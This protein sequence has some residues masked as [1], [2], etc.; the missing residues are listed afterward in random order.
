MPGTGSRQSARTTTRCLPGG[1]HR[2]QLERHVDALVLADQLPVDPH[3]RAMVH[4]LEA[5]RV[6][7]VRRDA[8]RRPVPA[9]AAVEVA[10]PDRARHRPRVGHVGTC[11]AFPGKALLRPT[12]RQSHVARSR[13]VVPGAERNPAGRAGVDDGRSRAPPGGDRAASAAAASQCMISSLHRW[14]REHGR[15]C[16]VAWGEGCRGTTLAGVGRFGKAGMDRGR[17]VLVAV[18]ARRDRHQPRATTNGRPALVEAPARTPATI[19]PVAKPPKPTAEEGA[20]PARQ[21]GQGRALDR[22]R[23]GT[24]PLLAIADQKPETFRPASAG[25]ASRAAG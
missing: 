14:M 10:P 19:S 24:G 1:Q 13:P 6:R 2:P 12:L 11:T 4:R 7:P 20:S 8:D 21:R 23:S 16:E 18:A 15:R 5:H 17:C 22:A 3:R 25:S 9:H